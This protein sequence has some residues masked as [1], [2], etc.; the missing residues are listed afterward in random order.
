[1]STGLHITFKGDYTTAACR[2]AENCGGF[3]VKN[4]ASTAST[5]NGICVAVEV[6]TA[7]TKISNTLSFGCIVTSTQFAAV[8]TKIVA[9]TTAVV[10]THILAA[11]G[12]E[13]NWSD[14]AL[15]GE[16]GSLLYL[17]HDTATVWPRFSYWVPSSAGL[18]PGVPP[19][20]THGD[21]LAIRCLDS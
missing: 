17:K 20:L 7:V 21:T 10:W 13:T 19:M 4:N 12:P 3:C 2:T 8:D 5:E 15:S 6:A 11:Y 1:V 16:A 14:T 9:D 18:T